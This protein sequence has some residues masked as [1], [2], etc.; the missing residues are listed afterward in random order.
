MGE[1]E[2][3]TTPLAELE[4]LLGA[5]AYRRLGQD[6]LWR[7]RAKQVHHMISR[8]M[9]AGMEPCNVVLMGDSFWALCDDPAAAWAAVMSLRDFGVDIQEIHLAGGSF[10]SASA[11]NPGG[12]VAVMQRLRGM[13]MSIKDIAG[14]GSSFWSAAVK[15]PEALATAVQRLRAMGMSVKDLAGMGNSFWSA[16]IKHPE[17]LATAVQTVSLVF[18]CFVCSSLGYVLLCRCKKF[19]EF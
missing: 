10:W 6:R 9:E 19:N 2:E 18:V 12:L 7:A 5:K 14:M 11:T 17:A 4:T 15:H 1:V 8:L 13:G 16:S 3:D